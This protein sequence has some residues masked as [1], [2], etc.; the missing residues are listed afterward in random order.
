ML[1]PTVTTAYSVLHQNWRWPN[2]DIAEL[3]CK[4]DGRYCDGAYWH[5]PDFLDHLQD[6]RERLRRPLVLTSAHRCPLWNA[7]VGGAPLSQHKTLAVDV[8]L[9]GH[10]RQTLFDQARAAGFTGFGL[11]RQFL[12]LDLR[13][14]PA[15]WTYPGSSHLWQT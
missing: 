13:P 7:A 4:C 12:H 10:D 11:A 9:A 8:A 5:A 1:F 14:H 2:F 15:I 6:L 3:A